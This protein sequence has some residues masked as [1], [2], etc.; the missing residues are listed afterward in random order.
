MPVG[1]LKSDVPPV[2]THSIDVGLTGFVAIVTVLHLAIYASI[3][4]SPLN[5]TPPVWQ[6]FWDQ[7]QYLRSAHALA[8]GN[9]NPLEHW[10]ALGYP[11][12]AVPF[13]SLIPKDPYFVVNLVSLV[14]FAAAFLIYFRPVIGTTATILGFL[15][16]QLI[17]FSVD[18]PPHV[19]FP[20][21]LQ[22]VL[23]WSTIP[24]AAIVM[25]VLTIV[26]GL[27]SGDSPTKDAALGA[28]A[29]AVV[30]IRPSD[31]LPLLI[32][33]GWYARQRAVTERAIRHLGAGLLAAGIVLGLDLALTLAI[34]GGLATPYHEQVRAIGASL[35][36][37][38]ERVLAIVVDAAATHGEPRTALLAI[39]PW[40]ALAIPLG[41]AWA[42]LDRRH[43]LLVMAS[44]ALSIGAYISFNDFWPY[45][46]LRLSLIHY[47][48]W[49][50]PI[51]TAGGI[52]GA[53]CLVRARRWRSLAAV[54]A[55]AMLL[56]SVR[57][58]AL[59]VPRTR[60]SIEREP[61]GGTRY[62]IVLPGAHDVDAIDLRGAATADSRGVTMKS[63]TVS[64][65][66]TPL[67]VFKGYR[68]MQLRDVLRIGFTRH[69]EA[70]RLSLV[71]DRTIEHH[72]AVP[73][74]VVALEFVT[75]LV[76][77]ARF[78]SK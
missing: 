69:V 40:L 46:I 16:A 18:A 62:D 7:S 34:Y 51:L 55:C 35:S 72:P 29:A 47:V 42:I 21:W 61:N 53:L 58:V 11:L 68:A 56:A 67:E 54:L 28:L 41:V 73:S 30:V 36:D 20:V 60:V 17:P 45:A 25:V 22:Y 33:G 75:R 74:D 71:L 31:A 27:G 19:A 15:A 59:P 63:F 5:G 9:L 14:I 6:G 4:G 66:G 77:F 3:T 76:P 57:V 1:M 32:A 13:L 49:T 64:M 12:L 37:F 78:R 50:L 10:Y 43:G 38:H 65:D 2:R 52:A 26:R 48:V 44:V 39:Q 8:A 23:P 70:S 24:V